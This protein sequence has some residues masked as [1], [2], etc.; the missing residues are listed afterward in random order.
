MATTGFVTGK[1]FLDCIRLVLAKISI[2]DWTSLDDSA[3]QFVLSEVVDKLPGLVQ[4]GYLIPRECA[5]NS[6]GLSGI[7]EPIKGLDVSL[8]KVCAAF[9]AMTDKWMAAISGTPFASVRDDDIELE[10][11]VHAVS[12]GCLDA[13][14][15]ALQ[16]LLGVY[17]AQFSHVPS[18]DDGRVHVDRDIQA[19]FD[20][21]L[22]F[23]V[24]RR[25]P[26]IRQW[27]RAKFDGRVPEEWNALNQQHLG[28][29]AALFT[30]C[31]SQCGSCRLGCMKSAMHPALLG[32]GHDC[33][34]SHHCQR[35]CQFCLANG[36]VG[37]AQAPTCAKEAGHSGSCECRY[38]D[39]TCGAECCLSKS[40]NCGRRCE[41][42]VD[43]EGE[44]RCG[45][46]A[47]ACGEPCSLEA[48]AGRCILNVQ[49]PHSAHKCVETACT[50]K[51]VIPDCS[52]HCSAMDH[53][54]GHPDVARA[55]AAENN[56]GVPVSLAE[57]D[58]AA[59]H[60]CGKAHACPHLCSEA[61]ICRVDVFLKQ[62]SKEFAGVR[63]KFR[64]TYQEMNG[65]RKKCGYVLAPKQQMHPGE[66]SCVVKDEDEDGDAVMESSDNPGAPASAASRSR[67]TTIHYCD[68]RYP[69]CSYYCNKAH[70]HAGVH[71]TS[72]GNMRNTIFVGET[73]NT[74]ID[75]AERKYQAG[76][77]GEAMCNLFC[78]KMGRGHVHY[79]QCEQNDG[80]KCVFSG[81]ATDQ[82]RHCWRTLEPAPGCEMDELLHDQFWR[83]LGWEDPCASSAERELFRKCEFQCDAPDHR[84]DASFCVLPAWH[85]PVSKLSDDA[86]S[87]VA[88]HQFECSHV[89]P[90]GRHHHMF[91][92][93]CSGSMSGQ[94]WLDLTEA[95]RE[96]VAN[97][98]S[99]GAT[100][101]V[102]SIVTF[103]STAVLAFEAKGVVDV[104]VTDLKDLYRGGGT[105][106]SSGLKLANEVLSRN[107]F[108]VYQSVVVFFSDGLP[109][110]VLEGEQLAEHVKLSYA[111]YGLQAFI[112]GFGG[113]ANLTVL[114]RIASKMG[115]EYRNALTG[116]EVKTAF[117]SISAA[118]SS[119][120][121][122]ALS[123][124]AAL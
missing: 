86:Y 85:A 106:Y 102:M 13:V 89:A 92:L 75:I 46:A 66:H 22:S 14:D 83:T 97:C 87:C 39:H 4:M 37:D 103:G 23:F 68:V 93:D 88:G 1:S 35:L 82:R 78:S 60:M 124:N 96:Y 84:D 34:T 123:R 2:L 115:G 112:V 33:G 94:P 58:E 111:K 104:A 54:H 105:A 43:H 114:E 16:G 11:N 30:R 17:M 27:A 18:S 122:L 120:A 51:C 117:Y 118:L 108:A 67:D 74:D 80:K 113:R 15:Q 42:R 110:D 56:M 65:S 24:R 63:S 29:F 36:V 107:D 81:G 48:C 9:P 76:E 53:F 8:E 6:T 77:A 3:Q 62:S 38:G 90:G 61:G 70:G 45:V 71:S 119:R 100:L 5:G 28:R 20:A 116:T 73:G 50:Q 101:D 25:C 12:D 32:A 121:G 10:I 21:F 31:Q 40:P 98:V 19:R 64:Y 57:A 69:C 7:K 91:V 44:H 49:A 59:V 79:L 72:H 26:R 47:H 109:F 41:R 99:S 95:V 52:E 55:F